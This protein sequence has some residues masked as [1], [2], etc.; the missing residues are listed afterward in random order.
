MPNNSIQHTGPCSGAVPSNFSQ[1]QS[2]QPWT[3]LSPS[4]SRVLPF[5]SWIKTS[6]VR[7]LPVKLSM[8]A[9]NVCHDGL[10]ESVGGR[11]QKRTGICFIP[12]LVVSFAINPF[13]TNFLTLTSYSWSFEQVYFGYYHPYYWYSC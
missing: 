9:K 7:R 1:S 5:S 11:S 2:E 6:R 4:S 13:T 3:S 10:R 12:N 8:A